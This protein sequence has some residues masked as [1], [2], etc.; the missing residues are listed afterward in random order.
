MLFRY[1]NSDILTDRYNKY[2]GFLIFWFVL[3]AVSDFSA[4]LELQIICNFSISRAVYRL[5]VIPVGLLFIY[6][7]STGLALWADISW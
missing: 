3:L 4:G 1:E 5:L 6:L 2:P 7:L